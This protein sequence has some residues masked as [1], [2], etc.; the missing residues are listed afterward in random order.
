[1]QASNTAKKVSC[2]TLAPQTIENKQERRKAG[3]RP[4]ISDVK[5]ILLK[6]FRRGHN[7]ASACRL[8]GKSHGL[9]AEWRQKAETKD[10]E[11]V[12]FFENVEK[13]KAEYYDGL[14]KSIDKESKKNGKL[15][16]EVISRIDH[17]HWGRKDSGE[18]SPPGSNLTDLPAIFAFTFNQFLLKGGHEP[19]KGLEL[20]A[21]VDDAE[22][23]IPAT[24]TAIPVSKE[25]LEAYAKFP[26]P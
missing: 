11:Y 26:G 20:P 8:A 16:L 22:E 15:A 4:V 21:T 1:M 25:A 23:V 18:K 7:E 14:V 6:A 19:V 24:A 10:P 9:I 2:E 3:R 12:E 5:E 17:K 13:A